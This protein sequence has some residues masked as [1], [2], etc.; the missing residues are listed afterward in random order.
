[1]LEC[2]IPHDQVENKDCCSETLRG[3]QRASRSP[4]SHWSRAAVSSAAFAGRDRPKRRICALC[5]DC[6]HY[7]L[8]TP[9]SM[10]SSP[11]DTSKEDDTLNTSMDA[12]LSDLVE[13]VANVSIHGG[14]PGDTSTSKSER[15]SPKPLRVYTRSQV[16]YLRDSPLVKPPEGMPSLKDWYGYVCLSCQG[17]PIIKTSFRDW[18]EQQANA[19]KD[20]ESPSTLANG[21]ER[22]QVLLVC[23]IMM[24]IYRAIAFA[25]TLRTAVSSTPFNSDVSFNLVIR[26]I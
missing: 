5:L 17:L 11:A 18:N 21:R 14:D 12:V 7:L 3:G 1:M 25:E 24:R 9:P 15:V 2:Q 22:R 23:S 19:K 20:N 13:G 8:Y 16:L 10:T 26:H 6:R 4:P